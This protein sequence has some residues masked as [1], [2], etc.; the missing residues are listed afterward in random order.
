METTK[1]VAPPKRLSKSQYTRGITCMKSLW[2]YQNA[3]DK[4]TPP[5]SMQQMIFDQGTNVGELACKLYPGGI[6][7]YEDHEHLAEAV[8]S[9]K[10]AIDAGATILYEGAGKFDNVVVRADILKKNIDGT[11]DIIEVKSSTKVKEIHIQDIS[12]QKYVLEGAGF[13]IRKS[14]LMHINSKYVRDGDVDAGQLFMREEVTNEI[15][16][17]M[18]GIPAHLSAFQAMLREETPPDVKFGPRCSTPYPCDFKDHCWKDVPEDSVWTLTGI[19]KKKAAE[20]WREGYKKITDIPDTLKLNKKQDLQ[21]SVMKRNQVHIEM[22]EIRKHLDELVWPL[23]FLDFET[24][25]PCVPPYNNLQPFQN[26]TF[27]ASIH[28]QKEP[29]GPVEHYELLCE[30]DKDPRKEMTEFLLDSI[31]REGSVIAYNAPFEKGCLLK[32]AKVYEDQEARLISMVARLWD[33]ATPF[34]KAWYMDPKFHGRWSLKITLPV[35]VPSMSYADMDIAE[36]GSAAKVYFDAMNGTLENKEKIFKAMLAYCG[37][38]TLAMVE[39]LNYLW[40]LTRRKA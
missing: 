13:K 12:V 30:P 8:E 19:H 4:Q 37:Q 26:L 7:I 1:T 17:L 20:I 36:G 9:T 39:I 28:T 40:T 3:R 32:L 15:A 21:R 14:F 24:V 25:A 38:D 23:F 22:E 16:F 2:F 34:A 33:V 27:Q 29:L 31:G 18:D 35:L 5:D 11:W 6:L 10:K